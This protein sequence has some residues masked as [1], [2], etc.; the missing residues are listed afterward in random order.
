MNAP[1]DLD[2]RPVRCSLDFI[3]FDRWLAG[4]SPVPFFA[5]FKAA[6]FGYDDLHIDW[7]TDPST[8][9][10][11]AELQRVR[12]F[13]LQTYSFALP[14]YEA[15]QAIR[16]LSPIVELGAGT[17]CWAKLL[18]NMGADIIA[19][20]AD[21]RSNKQYILHAMLGYYFPVERR[22]G[23]EAVVRYPARNVLAVWPCLSEPWMREAAE[24]MLPGTRLALV[25]AGRG[26]C[27]GD[28]SLFDC[29]DEK[30]AVEVDMD[31]PRWP[32]MQDRLGIWRKL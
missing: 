18:Q 19:T 3:R 23:C 14:S 25:H 15:L 31:L 32:G 6:G 30:F 12:L 1:T 7:I 22:L 28:R 20:D 5:E 26:G 9:P 4:L 24:A 27:I 11:I 8:N 13:N 17:G 29:L 21:T 2:I 16:R 10:V